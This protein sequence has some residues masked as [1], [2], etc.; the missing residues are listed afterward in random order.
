MKKNNVKIAQFTF[1]QILCGAKFR[2]YFHGVFSKD[3]NFIEKNQFSKL[4]FSHGSCHYEQEY[5]F[6]EVMGDDIG[7]ISFISIFGG[8]FLRI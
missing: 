3:D 7:N 2:Q 1:C 5:A 8:E 6:H 4:H